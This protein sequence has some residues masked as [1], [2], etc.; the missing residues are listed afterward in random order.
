M[1]VGEGLGGYK[2]RQETRRLELWETQRN[3]QLSNRATISCIWMMCG[4]PSKTGL[5]GVSLKTYYAI[6]FFKFNYQLRLTYRSMGRPL[7]EDTC[8]TAV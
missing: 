2:T 5:V 1:N 3:H 6:F 7:F 4:G 8:L